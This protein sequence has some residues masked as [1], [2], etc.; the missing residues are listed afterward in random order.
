MLKH[1]VNHYKYLDKY[2]A[3]F[4]RSIGLTKDQWIGMS[5]AHGDKCYQYKE[6]WANAGIEFP[7]GAAIYLASYCYPFS[8]ETRNPGQPHVSDWV[9]SKY[10]E[11][12]QFLPAIDETD[13]DVVSVYFS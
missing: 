7:H 1:R 6:K 10:S 8:E 9:I 5:G 12:E 4:F 2:L 11:W 3:D 13:P